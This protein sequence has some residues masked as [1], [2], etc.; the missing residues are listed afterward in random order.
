MSDLAD[1]RISDQS[2]PDDGP[3][4]CGVS[5]DCLPTVTDSSASQAKPSLLINALSSW[6]G[7]GVN[8]V[9]GLLLLPFVVAKLGQTGYGV[10]MLV[11]SIIGYYGLLDLGVSS[12][13]SR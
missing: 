6:A 4:D 9:V 5:S 8:I 2:G 13:V 10:W 1:I 11:G 12:A 7:L 3:D